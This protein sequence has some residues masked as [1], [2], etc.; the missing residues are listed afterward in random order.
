LLFLK[1]VADRMRGFATPP[2]A[3]GRGSFAAS[4]D[5]AIAKEPEWIV[6][7]FGTDSRGTPVLRRL[8]QITNSNQKRPGPVA[9][10]LNQN[11]LPVSAVKV[12]V[13]GVEEKSCEAIESLIRQ[14]IGSVDE[15]AA[16]HTLPPTISALVQGNTTWAGGS[17]EVPNQSDP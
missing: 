9:V 1:E 6:D 14:I 8:V 7:V 3:G 12:S 4:L 16:N 5:Y 15:R 13:A 10:S 11:F 17:V 2:L